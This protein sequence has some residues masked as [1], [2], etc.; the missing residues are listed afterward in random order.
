MQKVKFNYSL[1]NIP[2]P[3]KDSYLKILIHK[4]QK[5]I[6]RIR[7]KVFW[8]TKD[9]ENNDSKCTYGFNTEKCAPQCKELL[10]FESDVIDLISNLEFKP[11]MSPFQ[12]KLR[13]DTKTIRNRDKIM[14][15]ADKTDNMYEVEKSEYLKLVRDNV[16]STYEIAPPDI[17]KQINKEAKII[18]EHLEISERV[19]TIAHNEAYI[20]LKDHK[21]NFENNP[22]CRLINPA[23]SNIGK[24]S[25]IKL[26]QIN[27]NIRNATGLIQWRNTSSTLEWFK[28]LENK[29]GL[30]F[31]QLDIVNF[32][33]SISEKLFDEAIHFAKDFVDIP[34]LTIDIIKNARK[35]LLFHD[36]KTW[37]KTGSL[38]DVTMGAYD[39]AEVCELVGLLVLHKM[40]KKFPEI[41]FGLYRDDG[42]GAHKIE[43]KGR[44]EKK[45]KEIHKLFKEL[46]L[47]ITIDSNLQSVNFL[48]VTMNMKDGK[49]WPYKKP[50]NT[51][52]YVH[53]Q[54]NH[55]P[56]VLKQIPKSINKRISAIS[57]NEEE[58]N[59]GKEEY[60]ESL[61]KS[62][63]RAQLKFQ[64]P[65]GEARRKRKKKN[66]IWY[67]PPFN[68]EL[69][70]NLGK[71]F[72]K[73]LDKH[74]PPNHYLH[75]HIN[76]K[77]VKISYSC[78]KNMENIIAAR[79]KQILRK[80]EEENRKCNCRKKEECPLNGECCTKTIIYKAEID[81][82][83]KKYNYIGCTEGEFKTRYNGHTDSFRNTNKKSSTTLAALVWE[84]NLQPKPT[85][86]WSIVQKTNK[87]LPGSN[88]CDLCGSEKLH[89]LKSTKDKN[90]INKRNEIAAICVHR[91]KFKLGNIDV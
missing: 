20:T 72:L 19:E 40:K 63:H 73:I 80:K 12:H 23:K 44:T 47:D 31:I 54:S 91:N 88:M 62:G 58:F 1:K 68:R 3:S 38:F 9:S 6:Q 85:V 27:K 83:R 45:K 14:L 37:K 17:E 52:K 26:Q 70:T 82:A 35:S 50:N 86:K 33:P 59:K 18:T 30:E 84:N 24:I 25:K 39:G 29:D 81:I 76:R 21:A 5:F 34:E 43:R 8:I 49:F 42:L 74:F 90:N 2:V 7:W 13:K 78:T 66:I 22:K 75:K 77:T 53:T 55:P 87:Y 15:M 11:E 10:N 60:Q 46:G 64:K 48:D 89:I 51:I 65:E 41:N 57:C 67:N 28:K 56:H 16:T 79:N 69:K 32:Y 4:T 61:T 36:G 71:E